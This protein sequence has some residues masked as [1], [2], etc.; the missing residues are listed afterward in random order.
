M[1]K[2]LFLKWWRWVN[3]FDLTA[4]PAVEETVEQM[5]VKEDLWDRLFTLTHELKGQRVKPMG[6]RWFDHRPALFT[7]SFGELIGRLEMVIRCLGEQCDAPA[8][9]EERRR[10][11][12]AVSI[13]DYSY[14]MIVGYRSPQVI[15]DM[16]I[17]KVLVIHHLLD[18]LN[19][20]RVDSYFVYSRRTFH[21]VIWDAFEVLSAQS[22]EV[23]EPEELLL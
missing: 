6:V 9:W 2:T 10:E 21:S 8:S 3:C 1:L 11:T 12:E 7:D 14:D 23:V 5:P 18:T 13:P 20:S 19:L 16:L 15:M 22:C 17:E 4:T